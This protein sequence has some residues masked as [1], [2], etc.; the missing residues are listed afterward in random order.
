MEITRNQELQLMGLKVLAEA[1]NAAMEDIKRAVS[2]IV[3][4]ADEWGH[5]SDFVWNDTMSVADLLSKLE[6]QVGGAE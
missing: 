6:I 2:E 4:D 3:G 5:A 1:H